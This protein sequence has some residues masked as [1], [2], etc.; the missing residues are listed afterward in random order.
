MRQATAPR[1]LGRQCTCITIACGGPNAV[2]GNTTGEAMAVIIEAESKLTERYQT[3]VP[4]AI[5]RALRLDKG[6]KLRYTIRRDGAVVL[7]SAAA[8][9]V[10]DPVMSQFLSFLARDMARHP[11]RLR[12]IDPSLARRIHTLVGDVRVDLDAALSPADD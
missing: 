11:Q 7:S 4:E 8:S 2:L 3:T 5:R 9:Q 1:T 6:G 12:A 10:A